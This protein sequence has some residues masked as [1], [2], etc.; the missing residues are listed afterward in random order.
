[1]Q[2]CFKSSLTALRA[3]S[4]A[5]RGPFYVAF[6]NYATGLEHLLKVILMLDD[7]HRHR[8]FPNNELLKKY[9]HNIVKLCGDAKKLFQ[10]YG[11]DWKSGCLPSGCSPTVRMASAATNSLAPSV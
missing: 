3:G 8:K 1:M 7:W 9:G 11:V 10:Q 4:S 6:F 5:E 2:G